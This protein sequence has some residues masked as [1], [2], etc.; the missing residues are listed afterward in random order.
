MADFKIQGGVT[1][2]NVLS[3]AGTAVLMALGYQALASD[4]KTNSTWIEKV[5]EPM[6]ESIQTDRLSTN[7]ILTSMQADI[8]YMRERLDEMSAEVAEQRKEREVGGH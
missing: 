8:R 4:V 1:W 3:I 7:T 5:G 2:G 6:R